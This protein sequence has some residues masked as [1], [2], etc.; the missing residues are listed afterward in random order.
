MNRPSLR[1]IAYEAILASIVS[2]QMPE[3]AVTSEI[4]LARRLDMSRTPIRA[5]LQQLE[6][7]GFVRIA[8]KHG[9]LIIPLSAERVS[10]LLETWLALVSFVYEQHKR[11][12]PA[13]IADVAS[14]FLRC[15]EDAAGETAQA[16]AKVEG[17]MWLQWVSLAHNEE[18]IRLFRTTTARL[19]WHRNDRRWRSPHRIE[20]E[21]CLKN[22]LAATTSSPETGAPDFFSYLHI[23]K[24]TWH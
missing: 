11:M 9:I 7:E 1:T 15:I 13:K 24:K 23:L 17:E 5:A 8:P 3:G 18:I 2:G 19:R 20:T 6:M 14:I 12:R 10:D 4:E 21:P 22:L 16:A